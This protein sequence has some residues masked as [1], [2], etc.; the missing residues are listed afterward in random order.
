MTDD[1]G[2]RA[3]PPGKSIEPRCRWLPRG[4]PAA[5]VLRS[6]V[7]GH[8]FIELPPK[9]HQVAPQLLETRVRQ[10]SKRLHDRLERDVK[11]PFRFRVTASE[12]AVGEQSEA[13]RTLFQD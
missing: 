13:I 6:S 8:Q 1:G 2:R 4:W 10:R 5:S 7:G 12:L 3:N 11:I 9:R